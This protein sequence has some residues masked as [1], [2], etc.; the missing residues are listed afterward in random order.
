[1]N[2]R[3]S[4]PQALADLES[5]NPEERDAAFH[6][7]YNTPFA[8]IATAPVSA[9][10]RALSHPNEGL[11]DR[12]VTALGKK[13]DREAVPHLVALLPPGGPLIRRSVVLALQQIGFPGGEDLQALLDGADPGLRQAAVILL[14]KAKDR[15]AAP[16]LIAMLSSEANEN[17]RCDLAD[18]LANIGAL[19]AIPALAG[20]LHSGSDAVEYQAF[21]ALKKL[22]EPARPA[23]IEA[24][25]HPNGR[26]RKTAA[27][28]FGGEADAA[29]FPGLRLLLQDADTAVRI[30]AAGTLASWIGSSSE[31]GLEGVVPALKAALD[32]E[33]SAVRHT[34]LGAF[35]RRTG[36]PASLPLLFRFWSDADDDIHRSVAR[37]LRTG[38]ARRTLLFSSGLCTTTG[39]C[40]GRA[41]PG[42]WGSSAAPRR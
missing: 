27:G 30:S 42:C 25:A 32:D 35:V 26:V 2:Q 33:V 3:L 10:I 37:E 19:E 41:P 31:S 16:A 14:G 13:G 12:M 15:R 20:A 11:R 38:R 1:M 5:S 22:G 6:A 24:L 9:L 7:L 34:A 21:L 39:R 23:W 4:A 17:L 28:M 29:A 8:E 40:G 36:D 18:A